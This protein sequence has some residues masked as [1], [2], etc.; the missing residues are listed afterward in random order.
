MSKGED[1]SS[2]Y[3]VWPP[4][5]SYASPV[6][7]GRNCHQFCLYCVLYRTKWLSLLEEVLGAP[8]S[9]GHFMSTASAQTEDGHSILLFSPSLLGQVHLQGGQN[10]PLV[11]PWWSL[12]EVG[13]LGQTHWQPGDLEMRSAVCGYQMMGNGRH[14]V[15]SLSLGLQPSPLLFW[16]NTCLSLA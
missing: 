13:L 1:A 3:G 16:L 7:S 15:S 14:S 2:S 12:A 8:G 6:H 5:L 10:I 11:V 4:W 9:L